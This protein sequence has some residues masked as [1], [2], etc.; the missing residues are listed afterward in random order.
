MRYK[1]YK[2]VN[3][4]WVEEIPKHWNIVPLKSLLDNS[5][6]GMWGNDEDDSL[7]ERPCVR[8][9]DFEF[10]KIGVR[11]KIQTLRYYKYTELLRQIRKGDI[12]IEKSGGG[13]KT[14]VGRIAYNEEFD[15]YMCANFIQVLRV[16]EN[17]NSKYI[18]YGLSAI[19][20]SEYVK[21]YIKQTTGIQN[22]SINQYLSQSF[23]IPPKEEQE[24]IAKF[25]DWKINEIDRLIGIEKA[26]IKNIEELDK[27]LVFEIVSKLYND[28]ETKQ[29]SLKSILN[30]ISIRYSECSEDMVLL[31][32]VRD[33]GVIERDLSENSDN[34]N[35]IPEDLSNYKV[36][37]KNNFVM[38]KMKA[39][40]GSYGVS[41]L[42]GI[43]SPAYYVFN[44]LA[45][46][47]DITL[48]FFNLAIRSRWY[49]NE[50]AKYSKGIRTDQ[51]DF[52]MERLRDIVFF[53]PSKEKQNEIVKKI[54]ETLRVIDI[55]KNES[56]KQ[57]EQ[58]TQLKQSLISEVVT[59]KVDIRNI[60]IPE[61]EKVDSVVEEEII[62][63]EIE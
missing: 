43:V 51:W 34:Y 48:D 58:L 50:F 13:E 47:Q 22:L 2:K 62:D 19:Y 23:F 6:S 36:V 59:G 44:L 55:Q 37:N 41:P 49:V 12:L 7:E 3:L 30:P 25:L 40:Q 56:N 10:S 11:N 38:N 28:K 35:V 17:I 42:S 39:W 61:Y 15:D 21:H 1:V 31:S 53:Y 33:L 54:K 60:E 52:P 46:E 32:V 5:F 4:P 24:Q 14:P 20:F 57:I 45:E 8:V 16:K 63:L 9:A 27:S 26:K 29:V 18:A